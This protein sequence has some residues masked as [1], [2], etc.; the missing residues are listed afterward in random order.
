MQTNTFRDE[1][2]SDGS[3]FLAETAVYKLS[4][5]I[6]ENLVGEL[7]FYDTVVSVAYSVQNIIKNDLSKIEQE[8]KN[9]DF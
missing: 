6:L 8:S 2:A 3:I 5:I 4:S 9:T 1:E 7:N